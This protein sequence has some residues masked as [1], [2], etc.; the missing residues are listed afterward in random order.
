MATALTTTAPAVAVAPLRSQFGPVAA[1]VEEADRILA[2]ALAGYRSPVAPLV[3]H[4]KHYR[5]KRLRPALLL[6]TAKACGGVTPAHHTLAAAV[7]MIH[8]ATLVHDDVLDE[9]EV[10]RHVATVNAGWGN[11]V[12]ILLGDL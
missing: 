4:L 12:S 10:R 3:E 5:G 6:L 1:D 7:E 9:A 8:T 11:K 2:A